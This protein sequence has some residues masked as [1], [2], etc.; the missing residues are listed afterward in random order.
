VSAET[1]SNAPHRSGERW[2]VL[3]TFLLATFYL[4]LL[5]WLTLWV[6]VPALGFQWQPVVIT[7][8]SMGPMIRQGDIVLLGAVPDEVAPG[9]VVTFED[10][11]RDGGLTT[12]RVTGINEDGTYQTRGDANL[13]ADSTPV[14]RDALV[15]VGR[16]LVPFIGLPLTWM[17][18]A[19][20]LFVGWIVAT[21]VACSVALRSPDRDRDDDPPGSDP[22]DDTVGTA[23]AVV[24]ADDPVA[25]WASRLAAS[26][27]RPAR[28]AWAC[29]VAP[30]RYGQAAALR[31]GTVAIG[32]GMDL[33]R[34][35]PPGVRGVVAAIRTIGPIAL[36]MSAPRASWPWLLA[37]VVT[38]VLVVVDPRGPEIKV[39]RWA[40]TVRGW[41]DV[42]GRWL[43]RL[44]ERTEDWLPGPGLG[45]ARPA[46]ALVMIASSI[47]VV[48]Q[49][50]SA[51]F[52]APTDNLGNAFELATD[53]PCQPEEA[54]S[55]TLDGIADANPKPGGTAHNGTHHS[56]HI[57]RDSSGNLEWGLFAF[58]TAG[59]SAKPSRCDITSATM[60]LYHR[61]SGRPAME[62]T[63]QAAASAWTENGPDLESVAG[64]G[65]TTSAIA[66]PTMGFVAFDVAPQ[67]Q[68]V[69][70]DH[71]FV[72]RSH[73]SS[74]AV[75]DI[76]FRTKD[77]PTIAERP[78]LVVEW[79]P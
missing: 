59:L 8:G 43:D 58:D 28:V 27:L 22:P 34:R 67:M 10:P 57:K 75:S 78:Y 66:G 68:S 37:T 35:T 17:Q 36:V 12:H 23:G 2:G 74:T 46:I 63:V 30:V 79:G 70:V 69:T 21:A 26:A 51:A 32:R 16:L 11:T 40:R 49:R 47:V 5:G 71:G 60:Y 25:R 61:E 50:S 6:A 62:I 54:G 3:A 38:T 48:G 9:T 56:V 18:G 31:L 15:G 44:R 45:M 33:V 39:G 7:S 4:W 42:A 65:P 1:S 73:P 64:T 24:T 13:D 55:A 52:S 77:H 53:F 72:V 76:P 41:A 29:V 19:I 14:T 20:L